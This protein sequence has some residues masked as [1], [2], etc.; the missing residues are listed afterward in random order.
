MRSSD[1]RLGRLPAVH[2]LRVPRFARLSPGLPPPPAQSCWYAD[3]PSWGMLAND[4]ARDCVEAAILHCIMQQDA[5]LHPGSGL[6]A[7]SREALAFYSALTGYDPNDPATDNGSL[8]MGP[9][10]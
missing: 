4:Q 1:V 9:K 5:Y 2:D 8:V 6:V 7:T 3:I 10:G